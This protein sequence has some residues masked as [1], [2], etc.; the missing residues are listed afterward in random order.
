[1]PAHL[2]PKLCAR[3]GEA[4]EVG[5]LDRQLAALGSHDLARRADPVAQVQLRELLEVRGHAVE[6]EE[7]DLAARV[8][9]RGEGELALTAQQHHPARDA[10]D[11]TRLLAVTE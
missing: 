1:M 4:L 2:S 7:L 5:D 6:R 9:H 10:D 11:L 3:L 8:A